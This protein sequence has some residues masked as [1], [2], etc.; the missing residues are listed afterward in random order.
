MT[1]EERYNTIVSSNTNILNRVLVY[2]ESINKL[3]DIVSIEDMNIKACIKEM[4][5]SIRVSNNK[6][7]QLRKQRAKIRE[8]LDDLE[9]AFYSASKYEGIGEGKNTGGHPNNVELRQIKK[10]KLKEQLGDLLIQTQLLEKSLAD[11]NE[12]VRQFIN[13]LPQKQYIAVLELTYIECMSNVA[14]A[15]ELN[16][17]REFVN[18]ARIRGLNGLCEIIQIYLKKY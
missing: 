11:N 3:L 10:T 18:M 9:R 14:I 13:L 16:Y 7:Y 8:D 15:S 1:L 6:V 17:S 12:L 2:I 4:L 5:K